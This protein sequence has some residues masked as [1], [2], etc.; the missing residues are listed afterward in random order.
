MNRFPALV[1]EDDYIIKTYAHGI[2]GLRRFANRFIVKAAYPTPSR[3]TI[4]RFGPSLRTR[5]QR[6]ATRTTAKASSNFTV[7][8]H[9]KSLQAPLG[10]NDDSL[11]RPRGF[12]GKNSDTV[13]LGGGSRLSTAWWNTIVALEDFEAVLIKQD[14]RLAGRG[15]KHVHVNQACDNA[16]PCFEHF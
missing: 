12:G 10:A 7:N 3:G 16:S 4:G 6:L 8:T 2:T 5:S 15:C 13:T 9:D 1:F 14:I 11:R